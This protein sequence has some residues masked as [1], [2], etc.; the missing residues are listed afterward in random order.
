MTMQ[1]QRHQFRRGFTLIEL[2]VSMLLGTFL[3]GGVIGVYI[4]NSRTNQVNEQMGQVQQAS[5]VSF[6][7][8]SR[9]VQHAGYAGCA[10]I[11][12][13]RVVNVLNPQPWWAN[14][15]GGVQGFENAAIP[16]FTAGA[17]PPLANTDGLH[18]MYGRGVSSSVV[19]H[20]AVA[21]PPLV[22]NQNLGGIVANDI[23]LG[24]DSRMAVIFKAT[25]VA[26][27]NISHGVGGAAPAN[28]TLNFGVAPDG[29]L[30]QQNMSNDAGSVMPLESV[31]WFVGTQ[32]GINSLFRV[33]LVA[34][35]AQIEEVVQN[36]QDLQ[37][38]YLVQGGN[39]Y[40]DANLVV[41][42][43]AVMS[44]RAT[45]TLADNPAMPMALGIRQISQVINLRNRRE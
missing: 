6:Q 33:A 9:D 38:Q 21:V 32:G 22:I 35:V 2:M 20:N 7:L 40:I 4:A 23:L 34:G 5:Q 37:L 10:N 17:I 42:W 25:A 1:L 39:D 36:V 29:S 3:I 8:L 14:W 11:I 18:L 41:D 19:A 16:D 44:I 24:C 12:S 30:F 26:G 31:G 27:N 15:V 43:G 28:S 45:L 13:T